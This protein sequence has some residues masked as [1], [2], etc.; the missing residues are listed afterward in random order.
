MYDIEKSIGFLLSKAHQRGFA[1]FKGRLDP[2]ELTPQQFGLMAFLWKEDGLSQ[3][4]LSERTSIDRTTIGGL[5]DRLEKDGW[6]ERRPKPGDRR[7][8]VVSLTV[9]GKRIEPELTGIA[10]EVLARFTCRLSED[11][12]E[13]LA[14]LL[15]SLREKEDV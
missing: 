2:Y 5:I 15:N 1:L 8:N 13:T 6:V 12:Q 4:E 10:S 3:A 7:A 14:R 11:E 9:K